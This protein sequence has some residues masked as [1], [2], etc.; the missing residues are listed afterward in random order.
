MNTAKQELDSVQQIKRPQE[1]QLVTW[2]SGG[3]LMGSADVVPGVSGGTV[4][5]LLGIYDRLVHSIRAG[6]AA[7]GCW[8]RLDGRAGAIHLRQVEWAFLLSVLG[9]ILS[10]VLLL[11]RL[12][13]LALTEYPFPTAGFFFGLVLSSVWV[14]AQR[15]NWNLGRFLIL[16][17]VA[18]ALALLLGARGHTTA[19]SVQQLTKPGLLEF[20]G[21]GALAIC[22]MILP[23]I[24][25][26]LLLVLVGMYS[27]VLAAL[28]DWDWRALL[29]FG[30]GASVGLGLFSQVLSWMLHRF[31][32]TVLVVL[33]G[34]MTGSLRLLWPWPDGIGGPSWQAPG[35][36]LWIT[37]VA[38]GLGA[39]AVFW[40][41]KLSST[42]T[43]AS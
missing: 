32:Q 43:A 31:Y 39:V 26:S 23:G 13:E 9:G 38:A 3:L 5:L 15:V 42:Q 28:N 35:K 6:S 29:L 18:A 2:F 17:G 4:A 7:V 22:A 21:A 14:V 20:F 36:Q 40:I 1:R 19:D 25:G 27:P 24:S 8:L 12:I 30:L 11:A 41:N 33:V 34:L 37:L 10:A 16:V